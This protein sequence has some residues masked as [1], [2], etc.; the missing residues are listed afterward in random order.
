M[1]ELY[2]F[3]QFLTEGVIKEDANSIVSLLQKNKKDVENY[4]DQDLISFEIDGEGDA[5]T[6]DREGYTGYSFKLSKDV[7]NEFVGQDGDKP[8]PI[9]IGGVDLMYI[10][11]NI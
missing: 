5:S 6:T 3:R 8:R 2:R 1:K 10:G 4:L 9:T 7:D 11:Y